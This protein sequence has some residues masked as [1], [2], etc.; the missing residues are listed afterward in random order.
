MQKT[1]ELGHHT[2]V[3]GFDV[4]RNSMD[5]IESKL[6]RWHDPGSV[7]AVLAVAGGCD[8]ASAV[9]LQDE[10]RVNEKFGVNF[11]VRLDHYKKYDGYYRDDILDSSPPDASYSEFSP[12]IA[13]TYYPNAKTTLYTSFGHSFNPPRLYHLYSH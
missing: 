2:I 7:T 12:K 4:Q 11:G 9:F 8:L 5:Y 13:L 6:A 1:W 3:T 10:Y